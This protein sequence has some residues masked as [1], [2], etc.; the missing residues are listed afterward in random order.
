MKKIT[1]IFFASLFLSLLIFSSSCKKNKEEV[2]QN[3]AS[4]SFLAGTI[5]L[6]S[7]LI[8]QADSLSVIFIIA[9]NEA[10]QI[11]AV[12]KLLPPFQYPVSFSLTSEDIMIAGTETKGNLQ[13][14]A[15]LDADGNANPAGPGDIIGEAVSGKVVA[16]D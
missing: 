3:P 1:K 10:G 7:D 9:R 13:I 5:E 4:N 15:R 11:V 16:G 6:Q 2:H 8:S 14:S 12:K